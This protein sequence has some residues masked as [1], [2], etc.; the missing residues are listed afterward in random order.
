MQ[1]PK[2]LPHYAQQTRHFNPMPSQRW[3]TAGSGH[4]PFCWLWCVH[5]VQAD[6]DPMS[7]KGWASITGAGQYP[8]SQS[9]LHAGSTSTML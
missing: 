7:V 5:R 4:Q 9:V 3:S 2:R 8:F 1:R 6:T